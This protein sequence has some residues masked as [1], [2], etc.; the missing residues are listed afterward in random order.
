MTKVGRARI[1]VVN[2][3]FENNSLQ[4]LEQLHSS[5]VL[6]DVPQDGSPSKLRSDFYIRDSLFFGAGKAARSPRL[7]LDQG[8]IKPELYSDEYV[9]EACRIRG[10]CENCRVEAGI[11]ETHDSMPLQEASDFMTAS[12]HWLLD[13]QNVCF[14]QM[15]HAFCTCACYTYSSAWLLR[16][17]SLCAAHPGARACNC[18]PVSAVTE[19]VRI[20]SH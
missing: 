9:F 14:P 19:A 1:S 13:V 12:D 10:D 15:I 17:S 8:A 16:P 7:L 20:S 18:V 11:C 2:T 4:G 6:A 5:V 3:T